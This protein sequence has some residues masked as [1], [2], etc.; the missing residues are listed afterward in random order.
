MHSKLWYTYLATDLAAISLKPHNGKLART[1]YERFP[2]CTYKGVD[3]CL[4]VHQLKYNQVISI[5]SPVAESDEVECELTDCFYLDG[6]KFAALI[7]G[8][9]K[10]YRCPKDIKNKIREFYVTSYRGKKI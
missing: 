2:W 3:G 8:S 4:R 5:K 7:F 9:S 6:D 1:I 10:R